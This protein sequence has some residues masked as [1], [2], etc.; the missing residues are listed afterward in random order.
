MNRRCLKMPKRRKPHEAR[1]GPTPHRSGAGVHLDRRTR[2]RRARLAAS[3]G[4]LRDSL[5]NG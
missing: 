5:E 2:R 4:A 3:G 1:R